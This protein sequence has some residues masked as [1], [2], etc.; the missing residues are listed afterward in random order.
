MVGSPLWQI[1]RILGNKSLLLGSGMLKLL[2]RLYGGIM[3]RSAADA[4]NFRVVG[5]NPTPARSIWL[6][7]STRYALDNAKCNQNYILLQPKPL[8]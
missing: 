7:T 8:G 3:Q 4:H 2:T 6:H 5:S 1:Q